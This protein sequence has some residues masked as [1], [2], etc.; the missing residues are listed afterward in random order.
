MP[1]CLY[2]VSKPVELF[3]AGIPVYFYVTIFFNCMDRVDT[4][5]M[6]EC[7]CDVVN[8]LTW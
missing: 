4:I 3:I 7:D 6:I 1:L 5:S 2:T 8:R